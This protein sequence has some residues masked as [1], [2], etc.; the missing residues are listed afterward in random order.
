[1]FYSLKVNRGYTQGNEAKNRWVERGSMT[2][3]KG[4]GHTLHLD[5]LPLIDPST[6]RPEKV[7]MFKVEEKKEA[8]A[9]E[10]I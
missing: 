8:V 4:K 6:G 10:A 9:N 7:Q 1:M 5:V 3:N 2:Q